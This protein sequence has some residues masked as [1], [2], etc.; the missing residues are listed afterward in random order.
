V[1]EASEHPRRPHIG[2]PES[3]RLEESSGPWPFVAFARFERPDGSTVEWNSRRHRKRLGL[4]GPRGRTGRRWSRPNTASLVMGALFMVGSACFAMGSLPVYSD[5]V[6]ASTVG[7]TFF[8]GSLFFTAAAY[9]QFRE[10][11]TAPQ[12]VEDPDSIP[13]G[14]R[15]LAAWAPDRI[16][17]WA[18]AIQFLGTIAFNVTTFAATRTS[19]SVIQE[20]RWIW[21][22]DVVGSVFF[23]VSSW[24]AYGEANA[25]GHGWRGRGIGWWICWL[26]LAG[27]VAF[28]A[29]A[30][31]ARYLHNTGEI[32][33]IQLVNLGTFLGAVCFF[34]GA[35]LLPVESSR[36]SEASLMP[37]PTVNAG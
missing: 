1:T 13:G 31:G 27:S 17:W 28:G 10:A 32:A 5:S 9:T 29:A 21:V 26:N 2:V 37:T 12:S 14:L 22:P 24:L 20:R 11:I 15:R 34:V 7:W 36:D 23:L 35:A 8:I 25:G 19:L 6:S 3:W 30:F 16:D 18:S 4:L 33:N